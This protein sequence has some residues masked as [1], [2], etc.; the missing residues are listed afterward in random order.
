[1]SVTLRY[2]FQF[3]P[4]ALAE[5]PD[6]FRELFSRC[7][8][9]RQSEAGFLWPV[10]IEG[11]PWYVGDSSLYGMFEHYAGIQPRD[12]SPVEHAAF[13]HVGLERCVAE[14]GLDRTLH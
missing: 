10:D 9:K 6:S 8:R 14:F 3:F 5:P 13:R 4:D 2:T 1:M 7:T 11:S 12:I